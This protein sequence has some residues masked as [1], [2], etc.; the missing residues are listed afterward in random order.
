MKTNSKQL[1][2]ALQP[3]QGTLPSN[4][5]IKVLEC[6]KFEVVDN[7]LTITSTDLENTTIN[8]L[9][10]YDSN[11]G[12]WCVDG[13]KIIQILQ[14]FKDDD[15]EFNF[16]DN[17]LVIKAQHGKYKIPTESANEYPNTPR[18]D[19]EY[20][21]VN[22]LP[23]AINRTVFSTGQDELRPIMTG[24]HI[25]GNEVVATDAHKLSKYSLNVDTGLNLTIPKKACNIIRQLPECSVKFNQTNLEVKYG[26]LIVITRLIYGQYPNYNAVIPNDNPNVLTINRTLLI[27]ALKRISTFSSKQTNQIRFSLGSEVTLSAEDVDFNQK[28]VEKLNG[29]YA[30]EDMA[31]G[32][33]SKFLLECLNNST[34]NEVR[35]EMSAPNRAGLVKGDNQYFSLLM[36]VMLND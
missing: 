19:G 3:L 30:G 34:A 26:N 18:L 36:P 12:V 13:K 8:S 7:T 20:T 33:N 31:I 9:E 24:V 28:A 14:G 16:K 11:N 2:Q 15:L 4:A 21:E 17:E 6:F 29:I 1:L 10:V 23:E 32:F 25:N 35:I 27:S 22:E 5:T